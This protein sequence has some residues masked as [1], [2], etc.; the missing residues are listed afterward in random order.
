MKA[1]K[2]SLIV[3]LAMVLILIG[4]V[5]AAAQPEKIEYTGKVCI[6]HLEG[7]RE[8]IEGNVY[9]Q[10][11]ALTSGFLVA[12]TDVL[13]GEIIIIQ[14]L[15]INQMT[16]EVH[17]FGTVELHPDGY[18]GTF[19]GSFSTHVFDGVLRGS[20]TLVGNGD[21]KGMIDFNDMSGPAVYNP[22]CYMGGTDS[23]GTLMITP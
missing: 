16:G 18:D 3:A 7:G 12:D 5:P 14:N 4:A 11:D 22:L 1:K 19:V 15:D 8:W 17:A 2:I 23:S 13:N 20:S 10:R 9:H 6:T 21:L